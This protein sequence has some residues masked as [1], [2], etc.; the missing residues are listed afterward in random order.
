MS[1]C[2]VCGDKTEE[3][4]NVCLSCV[5]K[6]NIVTIGNKH[7]SFYIF[8]IITLGGYHNQIIVKCLWHKLEVVNRIIK[9]IL[10]Y[11]GLEELRRTVKKEKANDGKE[12]ESYY[13]TFEMLPILKGLKTDAKRKNIF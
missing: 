9:P 10:Y 12:V 1:E 13:I 2:I 4:Y 11:W 7:S 5:N 6:R 8:K 3:G